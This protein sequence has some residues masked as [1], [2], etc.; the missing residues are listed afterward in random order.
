MNNNV[1]DALSIPRWFVLFGSL[2]L[3]L[4]LQGCGGGG[5]TAE[6]TSTDGSPSISDSSSNSNPQKLPADTSLDGSA[7][8][9]V[10]ANGIVNAYLVNNG[11]RGDLVATTTT[12][13]NG[14][15][16]LGVSSSYSG[17]LL[18]T[19]T[20]G[21][22]T[23]M[24]CDSVDGCGAT[25]AGDGN[26]DLNT[27]D[28]VDFG[29]KFS[30]GSDFLL[31]AAVEANSGS[32]AY[33]T[34]LSHLAAEYAA[35]LNGGLNNDNV[36]DANSQVAQIFNLTG[37]I[38]KI[39]PVDLTDNDEVNGA[40][41]SEAQ[42]SML[43]VAVLSDLNNANIQNQIDS[44]AADFRN[45]QGQFVQN[46]SLDGSET[47]ND[48][49]ARAMNIAQ[50]V[51]QDAAAAEFNR[52]RHSA[53][54]AF[55]GAITSVI[56]SPTASADDLDKVKAFVD[57]LQLWQDVVKLEGNTDTMASKRQEFEEEL[58]PE[59]LVM[60]TALSLSMQWG[61][62]PALPELAINTFCNS[63][64]N[65][66]TAS[67]CKSLIDLDAIEASCEGSG[68]VLFGQNLCDLLEDITIINNENYAVHY[69]FFDGMVTVDGTLD[70][71]T[72]DLEMTV[73]TTGGDSLAFVATGSVESDTAT[74]TLDNSTVTFDFD[75]AINI[76][77]LSLPE[78]ITINVEGGLVQN[79]DASEDPVSFQGDMDLV[80]DLSDLT[81]ASSSQSTEDTLAQT[82]SL[83]I[84][85]N[86]EFQLSMDGNYSTDSGENY[87]ADFLVTG[88]EE[89]T[90]TLTVDLLSQDLSTNAV[91]TVVGTLDNSNLNQFS[92]ELAYDGKLIEIEP[93]NDDNN[94]LIMTNQDNVVIQIDTSVDSDT[95]G[96]AT[97]E[98]DS[99][100]TI[101]KVDDVYVINYTD[102]T[103]EVLFN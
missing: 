80:V 29:E 41:T 97:V 14:N 62:L 2:F 6:A 75:G 12:D 1:V 31:S 77:K 70:D 61:F 19:L 83:L 46:N 94:I 21:S 32:N 13:A 53:N 82:S 5:S 33:I 16:S 8:K 68:L 7:I 101:N 71:K 58:L 45:N 43:S 78:T 30:L 103:S 17:T 57:D 39:R 63:L 90:Y 65:S 59:L 64:G 9:G 95:A 50:H 88:G 37:D 52:M 79:A 60:E 54:Q 47:L 99:Q 85:D 28:S 102:D 48:I 20:A 24:T 55:T 73:S 27:N 35:S 34:T 81:T 26:F 25:A 69:H 11:Q 93:S 89:T 87:D 18:L 3:G 76:L 96:H 23:T 91:A 92:V 86:L 4:S 10:I 74:L 40:S 22:N 67:I 56:A 100:G 44:L 38:T 42:L 84:G 15:F 51:S 49:S 98:G 72:V 66:F 36:A